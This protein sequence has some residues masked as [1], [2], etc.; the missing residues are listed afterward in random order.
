MASD[1]TT[2]RAG[3]P[4]LAWETLL[5]VRDGPGPLVV[6]LERALRDAVRSGRAP[7]GAALPASRSLAET[8]GVSRWV[9]TEVYGQLVAEGVL[10]ARAGSAT[11]V[12]PGGALPVP[13][14][15]GAR[16]TRRAPSSGARWNLAPGV[17]DLR[18]APLDAWAR[19][20]REALAAVSRDDLFDRPWA[21]HPGARAVVAGHLRRSRLVSA[22][23]DDVVLTHG[24][25][26]GMTIASTA[27]AGAGHTH[28]LVE[29]PCWPVLRDVARSAGLEP[30]SVPVG[31]GGIDVDAF[32]AAAA[33]TGARAA[34]LTPAHQ[35]PT[36]EAL[37]PQRRHRLLEWARTADGLLIEDDYDAEFRYDRRPVAAL[38]GA[39]PERVLLLGSLSKTFGP[40]FG[41][42]WAVVP[43]GWQA[44]FEVAAGPG[45][46][47]SVVDQLTFARLV[48][49]GGYDRHLRA[50]RGRYRRRRDAVVAALA[51]ELPNA[52]VGGIAAGMHLL[53]E[54]PGPVDAADVVREAA[55]R[56]VAVVDLR[57]YRSAPGPSSTLVLG[58]GDLADARVDEAVALLAAAVRASSSGPG[59]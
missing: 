31:P 47:P 27:L 38:Q 59:V 2:S 4:R 42:G 57:R 5:D 8:L 29:Q 14:D 37:A 16:P 58:Y 51:R 32:E 18:H 20:T 34:L 15:D 30:V 39:D 48:E 41:L 22:T 9:V 56:G 45:A 43:R 36:G 46:G 21:G 10:E 54:L 28:L 19:A 55:R 6:R 52:T 40:V 25:T 44:A 53:V 7:A 35:F 3:E 12:A 23:A 1:Q 50:Q 13:P 24:A 33:R 49:S 11:R 17:P 26:H